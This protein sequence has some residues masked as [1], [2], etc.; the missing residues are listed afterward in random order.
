MIH[1]ALLRGV[2]VSGVRPVKLGALREVIE[3]LGRTDVRTYPP[4]DNVVFRSAVA[5]GALRRGIRRAIEERFGFA[6][7][8][9]LRSAPDLERVALTNPFLNRSG[10][11]LDVLYVT[12]LATLCRGPRP[13]TVSSARPTR[14]SARWS[15]S[16]SAST[17]RNAR[18][19]TCGG[20][21]YP[22]S[23]AC[24]PWCWRMR[25]C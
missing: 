10:V 24:C 1:V 11:A 19:S 20:G 16:V 4:S 3:T 25:R 15:I 5:S 21:G 9:L 23:R 6:V 14:V 17:R 7:D 18:Y 13:A 2:N 12:L 22:C 8:V